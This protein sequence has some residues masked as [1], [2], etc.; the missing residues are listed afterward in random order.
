MKLDSLHHTFHFEIGT[1]WCWIFSINCHLNKIIY[2]KSEINFKIE[3]LA[4]ML[5]R[6]VIEKYKNVSLESCFWFLF[7]KY[8]LALKL[9]IYDLQETWYGCNKVMEFWLKILNF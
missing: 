1:F 3:I 4:V 5:L 2:Y 6:I 8:Q 9:D 7:A